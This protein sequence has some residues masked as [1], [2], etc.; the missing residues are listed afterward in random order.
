VFGVYE[1]LK[2][3]VFIVSNV[4]KVFF[5]IIVVMLLI[6]DFSRFLDLIF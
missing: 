4:K 6:L 1:K 2:V 3:K 5:G